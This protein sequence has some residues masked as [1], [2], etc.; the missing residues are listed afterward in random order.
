L[1]APSMV[2]NRQDLISVVGMAN[3]KTRNAKR[4]LAE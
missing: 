2:A 1:H 4:R 3:T